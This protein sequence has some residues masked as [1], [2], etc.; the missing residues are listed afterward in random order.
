MGAKQGVEWEMAAWGRVWGWNH[1][2][3][4]NQGMRKHFLCVWSDFRRDKSCVELGLCQGLQPSGGQMW[5][6]MTYRR[7]L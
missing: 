7:R 2:M 6:D 5:Y 4:R 3:V 1:T